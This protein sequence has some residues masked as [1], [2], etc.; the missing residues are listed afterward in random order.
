M[1]GRVFAVEKILAE[2]EKVAADEW[3][4][5][6]VSA[7]FS[8]S[9]DREVERVVVEKLRWSRT[10]AKAALSILR[11]SGHLAP[12]VENGLPEDP[13][14]LKYWFYKSKSDVC[15]VHQSLAQRCIS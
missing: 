8:K 2:A 5:S 3:L 10:I 6:L 9:T 14:D 7:A 1:P 12:L 15:Y 11:R 13:I 4:N